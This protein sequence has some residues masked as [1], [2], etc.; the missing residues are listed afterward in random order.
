MKKLTLKNEYKDTI[1]MR[2][3]IFFDTNKVKEEDYNIYY[4]NGFSDIFEVEKLKEIVIEPKTKLK[5]DK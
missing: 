4:E 1:I 5:D 2:N 3:D